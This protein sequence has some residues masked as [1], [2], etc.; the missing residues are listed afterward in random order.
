MSHQT[1]IKSNETLRQFF[2]KSKQGHIR[3]LKVVINDKEELALDAHKEIKSS[4]WRK[5]YD[6]MVLGVIEA[7]MP[8][9]VFVRFDERDQAGNYTWLLV[10]WSP[11]LALVKH[12][13]L[14]AATKS[15]LKLEFG[16]G[17]IKDELFGT[18]RDDITY[19]GY[20]RHVKAQ[21]APAPLTNRE[22][23]LEILKQAENLSR[24]NVDTKHKTLQ[25]V[26][27]PFD[28]R[29]QDKL[30]Q[31]K[32]GDVDYVKLEIDIKGEKILL[33]KSSEKMNVDLLANEMPVDK[34]RFHLYRYNHVHDGVKCHSVLFI[35]SMP[36]FS[37]SVKERMVYSSTKSELLEYLKK[38]LGL[39]IAKT[40]EISEPSEISEQI[41][42]D[43]LHPK[44]A[45]EGLKFDKPKG[46][47]SRGPKRLVRP[48]N[49]APSSDNS[50][51]FEF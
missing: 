42:L 31:F 39:E 41:F 13:M 18:V 33:D 5:D 3:L 45:T 37:S 19:D 21:L 12:K 17:Q 48:S 6:D 15:T 11:D 25:G 16:A 26:M 35:Y 44:K 47:T 30:S 7:K 22:E 50:N 51:S 23:E 9:Y 32:K 29:A 14:Y 34:G 8:C 1:G 46:P 28:S 24:I 27:F 40:F 10:C 38:Q 2:A 36:G 20:M 49:A 43:E 4:D